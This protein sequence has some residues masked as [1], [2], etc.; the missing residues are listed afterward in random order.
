[1]SDFTPE[2]A[3]RDLAR[4]ITTIY[5]ALDS[6]I[7]KAREF[8]Q[9]QENE[10]E[11]KVDRYLAPNIVRFHAVRYLRRAGQDAYDDNENEMN[12]SLIP[13]NGIHVNYGRYKIK[14]LKSNK[15]DL[16]IPGHSLSRRNFYDQPF[17]RYVDNEDFLDIKLILLWNVDQSYTLG[18]LSLACPKS[19]ELTRESVSHHWHCNIPTKILYGEFNE[20]DII[21]PDEILDLELE[22]DIDLD[23]TGTDD[24]K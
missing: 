18:K 21:T 6:G 14:I 2:S 12:M 4:V 19:G 1:M 10:D 7:F 17:L 24:T 22:S 3:M 20:T 9:K 16:P 11:K 5:T 8:F 15:G 23:E 13:N